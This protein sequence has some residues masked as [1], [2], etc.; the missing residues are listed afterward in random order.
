M[1][2]GA[3]R[4]HF[5]R[6]ADARAG[7]ADRVTVTGAGPVSSPEAEVWEAAA[8]AGITVHASRESESSS[9]NSALRHETLS[10]GAERA[11]RGIDDVQE[12]VA[13]VKRHRE[14]TR[15][16]FRSRRVRAP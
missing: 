11:A 16:R 14:E 3:A 5:E 7:G 2:V 4:A 1:S 8:V 6:H 12:L 9:D 13:F 10:S 15:R